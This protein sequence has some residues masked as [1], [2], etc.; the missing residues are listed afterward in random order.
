M[1]SVAI[2]MLPSMAA[3]IS[4][5]AMTFLIGSTD[6]KRDST[7]PMFRFSKKDI[8][9]RSR[10]WNSRAP[11]WKCSAF[12]STSAM[13]ERMASVATLIAI[14]SAKPSASASIRSVSPR[15]TTSSTVSCM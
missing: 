7:S 12:C 10:W 11:I 15:A 6:S 8:G 2:A 13:C 9:R 4:P 14:S 3:R 1:A 5:S